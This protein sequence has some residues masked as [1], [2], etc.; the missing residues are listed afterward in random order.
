MRFEAFEK[1]ISELID[2]ALPG[3]SA[4]MQ[5]APPF[6]EELILR[7]K[8]ED[9]LPKRAA[10]MALFYPNKNNCISLVFIVRNS[11]DGVHSGQIGFPGGKPELEDQNLAETACRETWEEIGVDMASVELIRPLTPLYI[12][13]SNYDVFPF[14]GM[15]RDLPIFKVQL[16]EVQSIIEVT[17]NEILDNKN[18]IFTTVKTSYGPKVTVPAFQFDGQIVWGATAMILMEIVVLLRTV[19]KK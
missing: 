1:I 7:Q 4:Q 2:A 3:L 12:P 9:R 16:S 13:P 17:L 11:Y 5:M 14:I 6:R 19:L 18:I 15:T 10:V 8:S